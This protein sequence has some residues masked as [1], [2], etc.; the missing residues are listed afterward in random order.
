MQWAGY[1]RSTKD[2]LASKLAGKKLYL[3]DRDG[4]LTLGGRC[5]N[6][7]V[8]ILAAL[9]AKGMGFYVVT[10]NS[11]RTNTEHSERFRSAGLEVDPEEVLVSTNSLIAFLRSQGIAR[12]YTLATERVLD[13]LC[14][15]G[16]D[17][18]SDDPEVLVMTYDIEL[19]YAKLVRFTNLLRTGIPY[20][21]THIDVVCPTETGGVPDVGSFMRM[22]EMTT[23]RMPDRDFGKPNLSF[24]DPILQERGLSYGDVVMVGDRLYTDIALAR[25]C[26]L[27]S[28]LV[29]SGE[30]T[31]DDLPDSHVVPDLIV[32][33]VGD[34]IPFL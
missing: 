17:P 22:L 14:D 29:L 24:I 5:I 16:F 23:G 7:A 13:Q 30:A 9:R 11:S 32:D 10:N 19:T 8:E 34:L 27:T 28:V 12:M 4:T 26:D 6:G 21:V 1:M 25:G 31:L 3:F 33:D 18:V 20:Y 15:A 2:E